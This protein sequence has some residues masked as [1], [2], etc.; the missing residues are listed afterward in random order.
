MRIGVNC[1][2]TVSGTIGSGAVGY[3]NESDETRAVGYALISALQRR[4]AEVV[5]CTDDIA[6]SVSENLRTICGTA[7]A[8]SL[9]LFVSIHFNAGG[10]EGSEAY[11]YAGRRLEAAEQILTNLN[12]LGFENRG[13]KDGSGL[14]VVRNTNAP[15]VLIEVCFADTQSDA[16]RYFELG[17]EKIASAI[18]E[19]IIRDSEVI[20]V[21]QY[22]ELKQLLEGLSE[23]VLRLTAEVEEL[24]T[25]AVYQEVS[26]AM[27]RWARET[28]QRLIDKGYLRGLDNGLN[29]TEEMLRL[30]VINDRAGLYL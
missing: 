3:L 4:G 28:V 24:K 30:L 19:A 7:N 2:H 23:S 14:Y 5:D 15:A 17:A 29:L 13:I 6:G 10:G 1:G 11:T 20:D 18:C 12:R 26:E 22:E 25:P 8:Q 9:D 16:H 21:T 27:P